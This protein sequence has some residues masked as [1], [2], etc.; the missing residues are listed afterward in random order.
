M[1]SRVLLL[2]AILLISQQVDAQTS[3]M[4]PPLRYSQPFV[5][6][7]SAFTVGIQTTPNGSFIYPS[8]WPSAGLFSQQA[9][10][11]QAIAAPTL[12]QGL[13]QTPQ[14]MY[15]SAAPGYYAPGRPCRKQPSP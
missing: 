2:I 11:R 1:K 12:S 6:Q 15:P 10:L 5:L 8:A 3:A 7:P 9:V 14:T 13:W 4:F